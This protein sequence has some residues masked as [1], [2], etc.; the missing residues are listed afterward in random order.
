M[1]NKKGFTLMELL[2][3]ILILGILSLIAVPNVISI[4][5]NNK[6]DIMLSDARKLISQAKYQV[7][8]N[9]DI[10]DDNDGDRLVGHKFYFNELNTK[11]DIKT[12]PDSSANYDSTSYV[13]YNVS[14]SG[15]ATYCVYLKG[16]KRQLG[17]ETSCVKEKDLF[18]RTNVKD[19]N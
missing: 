5:E 19:I 15:I 7:N 16:S 17:T 18:D 12:E 6:K 10:R 13:Y 14:D 11:N 4:V 9:K 2:A 1:V 8:I 3:V